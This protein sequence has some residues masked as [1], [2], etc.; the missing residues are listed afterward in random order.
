MRNLIGCLLALSL[1]ASPAWAQSKAKP[2]GQKGKPEVTPVNA[3]RGELPKVLLIGDSVCQGYAPLLGDLLKEKASLYRT[4][5]SGGSSARGMERIDEWLGAQKWDVI[6]FNWGIDDMIEDPNAPGHV[7]VP[8]EAYEKNLRALVLKLKASGAK[9]IW[10]TIT[11]IPKGFGDVPAYN[12]IA[13]TIMKEEGIAVD[14]LFTAMEPHVAEFRL[15]QDV[16]YNPDGYQL[17]AK[18]AAD[19]I[20]AALAAKK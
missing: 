12:A 14:D 19:S 10:A 1:L 16:H 17:L 7:Q 2:E 18:N 8:P 3:E 5:K 11:P 6:H 13:A 15:P 20:Q 4:R 9:L